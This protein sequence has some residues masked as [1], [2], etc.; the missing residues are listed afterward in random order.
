[1]GM[2]A[3]GSSGGPKN[4][5]NVTPLVDVVLVLLIIF[6]VTM[7]VLMQKITIEIPRKMDSDEVSFAKNITI[8]G[9]A[10]GTIVLNDG[11]SDQIVRRV[12]LAGL[13]TELLNDSMKEK[14]VFVD[15]EDLLPYS[16]AIS[17]MDTV[18]SVGKAAGEKGSGFV[19]I[20][21]KMREKKRAAVDSL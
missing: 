20:A 3:G 1:M 21:L 15:F 9:K 12:D 14:K 13:L 18:K 2:S 6:L 7:P 11:T 4:D 10:D 8:T 17:I 19:E 5:I 16:E